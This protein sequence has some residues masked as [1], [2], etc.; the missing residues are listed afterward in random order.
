MLLQMLVRRN[1]VYY[2]QDQ[3]P[4]LLQYRATKWIKML[5][6][7]ATLHYYFGCVGNRRPCSYRSRNRIRTNLR[8]NPLMLL[9][10]CVNTPIDHSVFHFLRSYKCLLPASLRPVS[11]RLKLLVTCGVIHM[12][13]L[14]PILLR[15][16]F[17]QLAAQLG[18]PS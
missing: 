1:P 14:K 7:P 10:S 5:I 13:E 8:A 11:T 17:E 6:N 9:A 4:Q 12:S 18:N 15:F 16:A 3:L 2:L